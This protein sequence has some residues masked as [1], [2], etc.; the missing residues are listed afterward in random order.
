MDQFPILETERLYL[1]KIDPSDAQAIFNYF[2]QENMV[3]YYGMD[4]FN[5]KEQ[6]L[7]IIDSFNTGFESGRVIRWG[8][9]RKDNSAF[10][11]TCG[12]H[13][14]S[15]PHNRSEIG[16]EIANDHW[17]QG[18]ATEALRAIIPFGFQE[19]NMHRIAAII[20]LE[21]TASEKLVERLG[22]KKEGILRDYMF[23]NGT[24]CYTTIYSLLK[25]EWL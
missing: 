23:Q 24:A 1:R 2:S 5:N 8:I 22:F 25:H 19:L 11:G 9:V 21:N 3:Q 17:G 13:N 4:A 7:Q 16:Y 18:F 15:K 6:A 14:I 12:F 20:F 10:I